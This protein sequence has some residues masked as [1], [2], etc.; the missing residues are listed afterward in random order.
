MVNWTQTFDKKLNFFEI[1]EAKRKVLPKACLMQWDGDGMRYQSFR[2][3]MIE[4]FDY[5][6]PSLELETLSRVLK[7]MRHQNVCTTFATRSTPLRSWM[8]RMGTF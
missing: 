3:Q 8:P 1:R 7:P 6:N 4:L 2:K 5:D